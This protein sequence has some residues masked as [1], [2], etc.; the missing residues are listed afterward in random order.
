MSRLRLKQIAGPGSDQAGFGLKVSSDGS[1]IDYFDLSAVGEKGPLGYFATVYTVADETAK[2]AIDTTQIKPGDQ[3]YVADDGQGKWAQYIASAVSSDTPP[4]VTWTLIAD[5][6]SASSASSAKTVGVS[7][8]YQTSS[9]IAVS[10]ISPNVRVIE[11]TIEV[12][13]AFNPSSTL[14]VG[15]DSDNSRLASS[16]NIDLTTVGTY[17]TTPSYQYS[18]TGETEVNVYL[19]P[20]TTSSGSATVT[21]SY[22]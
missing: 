6:D 16:D 12:T 11:V 10:E 20:G 5:Q 15:D 3:V 7:L 21:I 17:M 1:T 2:A 9:P 19:D 22:I 14:S 18:G 4:V 8:T 13:E